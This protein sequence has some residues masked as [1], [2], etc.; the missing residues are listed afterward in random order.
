MVSSRACRSQA[1]DALSLSARAMVTRGPYLASQ[2]SKQRLHMSTRSLQAPGRCS[3]GIVG[4]VTRRTWWWWGVLAV[5]WRC[6]DTR[7]SALLRRAWRRGAGH[8]R[9]LARLGAHVLR[10]KGQALPP[11]PSSEPHMHTRTHTHIAMNGPI[12]LGVRL[13]FVSLVVRTER[14][15]Q[16]HGH[17]CTC[18][19]ANET[20]ETKETKGTGKG[21][22]KG[23]IRGLLYFAV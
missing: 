8:V 10:H 22:G 4:D 15:T 20:K 14:P 17:G 1:F 16:V 13:A 12:V 6:A 23:P 21:K 9:T 3:G 18:D 19:G 11:P 7:V 2:A 5:C